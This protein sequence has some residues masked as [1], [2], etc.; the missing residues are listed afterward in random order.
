MQQIFDILTTIFLAVGSLLALTGAVGILRM[1]DFYSRLHP[2]GKTDSLAQILIMTGLLFQCYRYPT[3]GTGAAIRL[4]M[5]S[6]F[7]FLTSPVSTHAI[8]KA[9]YLGGLQPWRK[10]KEP[11]V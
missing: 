2:A 6:A 4:V 1:P 7:V 5:I 11:D 9:A 8:A 10:D 3:I